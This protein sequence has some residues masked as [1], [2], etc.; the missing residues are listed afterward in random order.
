MIG[1]AAETGRVLPHGTWVARAQK[2]S[3]RLVATNAAERGDLQEA[4]VG[5][6]HAVF[7]GTL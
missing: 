1:L 2:T 4:L 6:V 7:A 5:P 3:S